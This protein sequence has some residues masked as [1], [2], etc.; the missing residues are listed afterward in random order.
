MALLCCCFLHQRYLKLQLSADKCEAGQTCSAVSAGKS[1]LHQPQNISC[2]LTLGLEMQAWSF[3]QFRPGGLPA[4]NLA[5]FVLLWVRCLHEVTS[6]NVV[7]RTFSESSD[8]LGDEVVSLLESC[9]DTCG[10]HICFQC[11]PACASGDSRNSTSCSNSQN[12]WRL[13]GADCLQ[14]LTKHHLQRRSVS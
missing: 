13:P 3:A 10:H 5:F 7:K 4:L 12:I 8:R 2:M 1:D 9:V 14:Q 11:D 6:G